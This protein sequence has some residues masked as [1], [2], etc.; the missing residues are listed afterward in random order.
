MD[1]NVV[2]KFKSIMGNQINLQDQLTKMNA[3]MFEAIKGQNVVN[4]RTISCEIDHVVEQMDTLERDRIELLSPYIEDKSRLKRINSF[5]EDFPKEEILGIK[6]L[7]KQLKEKSLQNFENT[8]VNQILLNEVVLE[9]R[10]NVEMINTQVNRPI[11][12]GF[13]GEKQSALPVHLVNQRC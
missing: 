2:T 13:D 9:I 8:R 11:K 7:H 4:V 6:E 1:K 12:Y 5:I 3:Q 10:K